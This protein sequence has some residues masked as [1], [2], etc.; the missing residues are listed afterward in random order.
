MSI[1]Y[2]ADTHFGHDN[3][4]RLS[5][6]PFKSVGEMDKTIIENWNRKVTNNDDVYILGDFSFKGGDPIEYAKQLNGKKH[7]IIGN[8]DKVLRQHPEFKKYFV[9]KVDVKTV[10]DGDTSVFLCHYPLV[11]WPGY[12]NNCIHLYGHVHNTFHNETTS[13]A[14][15]MNNAYNVGVDILNF[16]PCTL[17]EILSK[18]KPNGKLVRDKI[19]QII[20]A[21]G[22][23]PITRILDDAEYLTELDKKLLEEIKEYKVDRSLEE[24]VDILEVLFALSTYHG[25]TKEDL[26]S[27]C[28]NK[29][30]ERGAFADKI[31]WSGNKTDYTN[32]T[33]GEVL[34]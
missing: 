14:A 18:S 33:L 27:A 22:K 2:I 6:R 13:Y 31:F 20:K 28:D 9:E 19:P 23:I 7:L 21:T 3:I 30:D 26:F 25:Y 24:L 17:E 4:R 8:H 29:R 11:E 15:S 32:I 16:E 5:K 12:Y 10:Q 34:K 1:F